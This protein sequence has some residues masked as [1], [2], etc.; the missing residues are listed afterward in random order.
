MKPK[1]NEINWLDELFENIIEKN[2][3]EL[4]NLIWQHHLD[5]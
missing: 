4:E 5:T 3:I 1:E 2:N